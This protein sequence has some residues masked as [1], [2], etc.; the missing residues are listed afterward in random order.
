[1][2]SI[3]K[4]I[5][6]KFNNTKLLERALTHSS[7][8]HEHGVDSYERLE[9]VGDALADFIVGE[10]LYQNFDVDAGLLSKYRAKLVS[11]ENFANIIKSNHI[12]N[13]IRAGKSIK[14]VSDSIKA[15]VFESILASVYFD[16]GIN[17]ARSLVWR[18]LLVDNEHVAKHIADHIDYKTT[19]QETLQAMTPQRS[20]R[21]EILEEIGKNSQKVF[22]VALYVDDKKVSEATGKSHKECEQNCAKQYLSRTK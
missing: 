10:Y 21:F 22:T 18:L 9:Y 19:L 17:E 2:S 11:T 14:V 6:Y 5:G 12:D 1:M 4:I 20:F 7:Y 15:D 8:A 3:E 16:G 13:Y